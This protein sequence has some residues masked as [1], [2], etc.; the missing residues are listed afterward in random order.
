GESAQSNQA[1]AQLEEIPSSSSETTSDTTETS[2]TTDTSDTTSDDGGPLENIPQ[3]VLGG[4]AIL[5]I[6][7]LGGFFLR[8]RG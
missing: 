6:L 5:G 2:S 1:S 7:G 8:R 4:L 3:I